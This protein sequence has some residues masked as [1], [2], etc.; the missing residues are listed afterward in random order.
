MS[1]NRQIT[2]REIIDWQI[3]LLGF[4]LSKNGKDYGDYFLQDEA[5]KWG[6]YQEV[7]HVPGLL[8]HL[9]AAPLYTAAPYY[10]TEEITDLILD[11]ATLRNSMRYDLQPH[12]LLTDTGFLVFEKQIYMTDINGNKVGVRAITWKLTRVSTDPNAGGIVDLDKHSSAPGVSVSFYTDMYAPDIREKDSIYQEL[13]E[14]YG[15]W[16][17]P[18]HRFLLLSH[19]GMPFGEYDYTKNP[20]LADN[21]ES[22][23][24]TE[25][26]VPLSPELAERLR[27]GQVQMDHELATKIKEDNP[28]AFFPYDLFVAA[29]LVMNQKVTGISGITADRAV[30]RRA[31]RAGMTIPNSLNIITLRRL[32]DRGKIFPDEEEERDV[33]WSHRWWVRG[34]WRHQ[35]YPS[36]GTHE[37]IYIDPYI[38]GPETKP[39]VPKP[40]VFFLER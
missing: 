26:R 31:K 17:T 9:S 6:T 37:W 27:S 19:K 11:A 29:L 34:H 38:K 32:V 16:P 24:S 28:G 20:E 4:W 30:M 3:E 36:R 12:H 1:R 22:L 13:Y 10:V 23:F 33:N 15:K 14:K 21:I 35:Y 2:A 7:A 25:D 18:M 39:I 8:A 40:D 5:E